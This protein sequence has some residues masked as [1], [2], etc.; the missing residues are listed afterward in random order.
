MSNE[1]HGWFEQ[2]YR[3]GDAPWDIGRPQP[4]IVRAAEQGLVDG[5]V[6]DVG[7]GTGENALFLAARGHPVLGLDGSA[8]AID[9]ARERASTRGLAARFLVW[10][11]LDLGRLRETFDTVVDCGLFHVFSDDERPLYTRSL[12]EVT[13]PGSVVLVLCFSDE[14]PPGWGPRRVA[15]REIREAFRPAFAVAD[16]RAARFATRLADDGAHAWFA[17]L[18]R[19]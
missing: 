6:L 13:A 17:R 18:E 5:K 1:D 2:A 3:A 10:D 11:A 16:L 19:I 8:T 15:E 9:R 7:C 14:E 4:E 12:A